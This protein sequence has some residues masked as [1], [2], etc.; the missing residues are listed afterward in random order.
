MFIEALGAAPA[1]VEVSDKLP[2]MSDLLVESAAIGIVFFLLARV[3]RWL[4]IPGLLIGYWTCACTLSML[5]YFGEDL[6]AEQGVRYIASALGSAL[7]VVISP[8]AGAVLARRGQR[9]TSSV[10]SAP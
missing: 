10:V 4:A 8:L 6:L 7:F 1:L 2:T 3:K 5:S 9:R